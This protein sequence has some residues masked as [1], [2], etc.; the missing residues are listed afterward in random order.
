M[1]QFT[2]WVSL[3][4]D[5][6]APG[7]LVEVTSSESFKITYEPE[8]NNDHSLSI[9]LVEAIIGLGVGNGELQN[10]YISQ[11]YAPEGV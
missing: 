7:S 6:V 10:W 5:G 4:A 1:S 11:Y 9:N 3:V 8:N 2:L